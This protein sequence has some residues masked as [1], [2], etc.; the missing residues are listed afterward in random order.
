MEGRSQVWIALD[1]HIVFIHQEFIAIIN[2]LLDPLP[3]AISRDRVYDCAD[4]G[5]GEL[6]EISL[7]R[8]VWLHLWHIAELLEDALDAE[9]LVAWNGDVVHLVILQDYSGCN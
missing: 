5:P 7:V 3:E 8:E 4:K 9:A 2:A 6:W 1:H